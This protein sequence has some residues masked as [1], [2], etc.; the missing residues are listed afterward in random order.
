MEGENQNYNSADQK[1]IRVYLDNC[2]YNRPYDDQS[3][4]KIELE[5]QAK[6]KIQRLIKEKQIELASS[7]MSL[8]ECGENPDQEKASLITDFINS[9]SSVFV[10]LANKG[11][12]EQTAM[13]IMKTGIKYKDACHIASAILSEADYLISTDLRM[14]K[15]KTDEVKL[16]NPVDFFIKEDI[17]K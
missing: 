16:I 13:E 11:S 14:L 7:Y 17:E 6:L 2:A 10:S 8:Y 12:I 15:Y 1:K 5:T 4:M 3:Q 9:N